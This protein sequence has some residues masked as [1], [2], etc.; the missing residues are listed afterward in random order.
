MLIVFL[1][2]ILLQESSAVH[3]SLDE[4]MMRSLCI[5]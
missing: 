1:V 5:V 2:L 3:P 4:I